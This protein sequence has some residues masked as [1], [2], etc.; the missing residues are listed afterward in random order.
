M[1]P[2]VNNMKSKTTS[3]LAVMHVLA[4]VVFIGFIVQ[5]GAILISYSVSISNPVAAKNLYMGL[6]LFNLRQYDF[7]L[8]TSTVVLKV[9]LLGLRSYIAWLIIKVLPGIK[10]S[11]PFTEGISRTLERIS[12]FILLIWVLSMVYDVFMKWLSDRAP[13]V[14]P[15]YISGDFIFWAG[16]VFVIAQ[17]FKKGV[18]IQSENELTV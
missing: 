2:Q 7:G 6:N 9:A 12:Y 16:I 1:Y 5:A 14:I 17:I 15:D 18:E 13:G 3:I 4:W 10:I 11:N 8:Y